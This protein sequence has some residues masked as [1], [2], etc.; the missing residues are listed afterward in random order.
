MGTSA[1]CIDEPPGNVGN[2]EIMSGLE[3][4]V[5]S[6]VGPLGCGGLDVEGVLGGGFVVV[7]E[8]VAGVGGAACGGVEGGGFGGGGDTGVGG[9]VADDGTDDLRDG[10]VKWS[11]KKTE[12]LA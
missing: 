8:G 9:G 12:S 6:E 2:P 4:R 1:S 7:D 3:N 11:A 5:S 10:R